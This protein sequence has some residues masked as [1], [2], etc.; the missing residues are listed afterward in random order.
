MRLPMGEIEGFWIKNYKSLK[1]VGIGTGYPQFV[2]VDDETAVWPFHLGPI[3]LFAGVCGS[4]KSTIIDV[5]SFISDCFQQGLD[6]ACLKRGGY[7]ALY[8]QGGKGPMSFGFHYRETGEAE[9]VTYALSV[10]SAKNKVPFIESELLAYR[11]G[12]EAVPILFLQNGAKSIRYLAPDPQIT[13]EQLTRVEFTDYKHLGL[14]ALESHPKYPVLASVHK[15]FQN[16]VL[17]N[18]TPDPARGLD[19]SLPRRHDSPRGVSLSGLVRYMIDSYG[20]SLDSFFKR[21]ASALPKVEAIMIDRSREGKPVLSFKMEKLSHA[22]PITQLSDATV[23]LF[24]YFL[25]L[26]ENAPAPMIAVEEPEN[27]LDRL[28]CWAL[29]QQMVRFDENPRGSQLFL[30]THHPGIADVLHPSQVWLLEKD[31][32]GFVTAERTIDAV[33]MQ[34]IVEGNHELAPRWFSERFEEKL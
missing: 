34:E 7:E 4:G 20:T 27:G 12:K 32:D 30:T 2:Y 11:R 13:N 31:P 10:A 24:T 28:H 14:A 1:Q 19:L 21:V 3:T 29:M 26:E 23:R 25:L 5:F 17:S 15:F 33:R 16:W 8:S 22:I 9:A 18:F 6:Y